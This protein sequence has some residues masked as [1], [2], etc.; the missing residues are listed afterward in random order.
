MIRTAVLALGFALTL[1]PSA[2]PFGRSGEAVSA[3]IG[4]VV[5]IAS[6]NTWTLR[7]WRSTAGLCLSYNLL[8]GPVCHVRLSGGSFFTFGQ[9]GVTETPIVG[10]VA[11]D[12]TRVVKTDRQGT[13]RLRLYQAPASLRTRLRFFAS[14]VRPG[15]PP[16]WRIVAYDRSG[17]EVGSVGQGVTG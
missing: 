16:K 3:R 15:K 14:V 12:V 9:N 6:G 10:A 2:L 7:G 13:S 8:G 5:T 4:P 1:A 17:Q 11:R